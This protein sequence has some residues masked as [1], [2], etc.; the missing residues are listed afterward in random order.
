MQSISIVHN[1][2]AVAANSTRSDVAFCLLY[3]AGHRYSIKGIVARDRFFFMDNKI[4]SEHLICALKVFR[5]SLLWWY[6]I[7][8]FLLSSIKLLTNSKNPNR[9]PKQMLWSVDFDYENPCGPKIS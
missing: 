1:G 7:L 4:I 6:L 9:N 5:V 3:T 8:N 2:Y